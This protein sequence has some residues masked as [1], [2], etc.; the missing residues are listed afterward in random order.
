MWFF[1]QKQFLGICY[2]LQVSCQPLC[3]FFWQ[4]HALAYIFIVL[5][6]TLSCMT[7][8]T[9]AWRCLKWE[10]V[11]RQSGTKDK[12]IS[13]LV[14]ASTSCMLT[15]GS[16]ARDIHSFEHSIAWIP[17]TEKNVSD[18]A[19]MKREDG[20]EIFIGHICT[21]RLPY[22]FGRILSIVGLLP[23]GIVSTNMLIPLNQYV[24]FDLAVEAEN[25]MSCCWSSFLTASPCLL[26]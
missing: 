25:Q 15:S 22:C 18:T 7:L 9:M 13:S 5:S 10:W 8:G 14:V 6:S 24:T 19:K 12:D 4:T 26:F 21:L 16:M 2:S 1:C 11:K 17:M 23:G 3:F 20:H